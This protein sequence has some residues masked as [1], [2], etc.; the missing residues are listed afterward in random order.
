MSYC[1]GSTAYDAPGSEFDYKISVHTNE[2][3]H[4]ARNGLKIDGFRCPL[5]P[6]GLYWDAIDAAVP[7]MPIWIQKVP[8]SANG[9]TYGEIVVALKE[10][11]KMAI[12]INGF[13]DL[14]P[15]WDT[16]AYRF[17][18]IIWVPPLYPQKYGRKWV[19]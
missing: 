8:A 19:V 11:Y 6:G 16:N 2:Y 13:G 12:D 14:F 10:L 7:R 15:F 5:V 3:I 17:W 1:W 4:C 9:A 18:P